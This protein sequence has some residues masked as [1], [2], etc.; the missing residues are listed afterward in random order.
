M[1]V[2]RTVYKQEAYRCAA[3]KAG[4]EPLAR[5]FTDVLGPF[6]IQRYTPPLAPRLAIR[7]CRPYLALASPFYCRCFSHGFTLGLLPT[8]L[9]ASAPPALHFLLDSRRFHHEILYRASRA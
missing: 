9:T 4:N 7:P 6:P 2:V 8:P 5:V 1:N 3:L